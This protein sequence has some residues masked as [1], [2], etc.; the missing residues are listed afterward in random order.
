MD[1]VRLGASDDLV[2]GRTHHRCGRCGRRH[3]PSLALFRSIVVTCH[4]RPWT[5]GP[6]APM[7]RGDCGLAPLAWREE[8]RRRL[9]SFLPVYPPYFTPVDP[10][11]LLSSSAARGAPLATATPLFL[12]NE[13]GREDVNKF[14]ALAES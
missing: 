14:A 5:R 11:L 13:F 6:A 1:A 12:D 8:G 9:G 7:P 10:M 2:P 4:R 3:A